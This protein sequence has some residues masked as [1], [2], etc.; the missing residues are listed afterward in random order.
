MALM[1]LPS[2]LLLLILESLGPKFFREDVGRLTI[3]KKWLDLAW[4]VYARDLQLTES[5][6]G[7][8]IEN[9]TAIAR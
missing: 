5:S 6:L 3:S 4:G 9:E 7:K 8:F 2:E 1:R